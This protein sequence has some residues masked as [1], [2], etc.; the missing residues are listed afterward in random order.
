MQWREQAGREEGDD[1][2]RR[3]RILP[4]KD[5]T[6]Y[7]AIRHDRSCHAVIDRVRRREVPVERRPINI[8]IW[9]PIRILSCH[10]HTYTPLHAN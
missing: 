1:A 10:Y 5:A 7:E 3:R 2:G 4:C 8:G 6:A 9:A